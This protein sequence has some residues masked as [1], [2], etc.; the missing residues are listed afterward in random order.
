MSVGGW[1]G[2][3]NTGA[4]SV[5][6]L[7]TSLCSSPTYFPPSLPPLFH[8]VITLKLS[9]P[10]HPPS[11]PPKFFSAFPPSLPF[12]PPLS[13]SSHIPSLCSHLHL[14]LLFVC[15]P[16]PLFLSLSHLRAQSCITVLCCPFFFVQ[17]FFFFF[18]SLCFGLTN[19]LS[20][21]FPSL[22]QE[23]C[24]VVHA[25]VRYLEDQQG[26]SRRQLY[27][28]LEVLFF[29]QHYIAGMHISGQI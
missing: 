23:L 14:A 11:F 13:L 12:F 29:P 18:F 15:P 2:C 1:S 7:F 5:F 9:P 3:R 26:F 22:L 16:Q 24:E 28:G 10:H 27:Q 25:N 21:L 4:R 20:L 17:P 8:S 19:Y 6:R